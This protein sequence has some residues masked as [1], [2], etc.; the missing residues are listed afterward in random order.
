[1]AIASS[2]VSAGLEA[3]TFLGQ[4]SATRPGARLRSYVT[5]TYGSNDRTFKNLSLIQMDI[6]IKDKR[7]QPTGWLFGTFQYNGRLGPAS[8]SNLIPLGIMWGNDPDVAGST[9]TQFLPGGLSPTSPPQTPMTQTKV[10]PKLKETSI[11]RNT[12]EVPPSHLGWNGRL[13]GP[14]DNFLSSCMSCHMT[15]EVPALSPANPTFQGIWNVANLSQPPVG[16]P[17]DQP[18][19]QGFTGGWYGGWMRWFQNLKCGQPFDPRG[20]PWTQEG[21]KSTDFSLQLSQGLT[22]FSEWQ[23]LAGLYASAYGV[24]R[25]G[26]LTAAAPNARPAARAR[27]SSKIP[28]AK[29][30]TVFP[31]TRGAVPPNP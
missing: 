5:T 18:P 25:T 4:C 7:A 2:S 15:A 26:K 30:H 6:A 20:N 19:P 3:C 12:K 8:W 10:N 11:N 23:A 21:A 29:G 27:T 28:S 24:T 14:V 31:I 9:Y 22:N 1:M 16:S 13:N 17:V